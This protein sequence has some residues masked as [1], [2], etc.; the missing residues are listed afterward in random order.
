MATPKIRLT[1]CEPDRVRDT[2]KGLGLETEGTTKAIVT[3]LAEYYDDN[4]QKLNIADCTTC[5]GVTAFT[6]IATLAEAHGLPV[7]SHGAQELHVQLLAAAPNAAYLEVHGFGLDKF[8][9]EPLRLVDGMAV[10][11]DRP[12]HGID[13]DWEALGKFRVR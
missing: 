5:G 10:A 6:K 13:F 2:L 12:G 1:K 8:M 9:A 7:I 11:P 4:A 3:R